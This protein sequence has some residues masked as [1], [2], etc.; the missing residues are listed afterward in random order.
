[1]PGRLL[2][3]LAFTRLMAGSEDATKPCLER[4]LRSVSPMIPGGRT[5]DSLA[6]ALIVI[7][8]AVGV[9]D[10]DDTRNEVVGGGPAPAGT[11]RRL[12]PVTR[13]AAWHNPPAWA[14]PGRTGDTG[15]PP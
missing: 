12:L 2:I 7:Q 14:I 1:M 9:H 6:G 10:F 8:T 4:S 13:L 5:S 15:A 3:I 11:E